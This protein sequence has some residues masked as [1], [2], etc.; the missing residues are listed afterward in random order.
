MLE[1]E[2]RLQTHSLACQYVRTSHIVEDLKLY[3]NTIKVLNDEFNRNWRYIIHTF[4]LIMCIWT[5]SL[6]YVLG[7][8]Q[9]NVYIMHTL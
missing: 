6:K 8:F 2:L 4:E 5:D 1:F 3:I 7:H 9:S